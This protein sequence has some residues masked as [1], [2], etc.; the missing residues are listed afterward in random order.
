MIYETFR[1]LYEHL[2]QQNLAHT[3]TMQRQRGRMWGIIAWS[4]S[5][6]LSIFP[7]RSRHWIEQHRVI[8][9]NT[10]FFILYFRVQKTI[11][12]NSLRLSPEY[13]HQGLATKLVEEAIR[14]CQQSLDINVFVTLCTSTKSLNILK[15]VGFEQLRTE[16]NEKCWKGIDFW[17]LLKRVD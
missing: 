10:S 12:L 5:L 4:N 15:S 9:S 16:E 8:E 3:A 2:S 7:P 14:Q 13:R 17:V 1:W 11:Y 6:W